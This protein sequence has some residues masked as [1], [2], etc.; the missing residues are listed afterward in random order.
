M[1]GQKMRY[2]R[3]V[4]LGL[5]TASSTACVVRTTRG[6]AHYS[7]RVESSAQVYV[8]DPGHV[9]VNKLALERL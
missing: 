2:M 7:G 5:L 6:R 3:W 4:V 1:S 9:Y 8:G